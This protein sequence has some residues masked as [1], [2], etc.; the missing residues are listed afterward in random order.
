MSRRT[1]S[2]R[3]AVSVGL[4]FGHVH[5]RGR[6]SGLELD[7]ETGLRVYVRGG[8]VV[9]AEGLLSR[10]RALQAAGLSE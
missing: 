2:S 6:E 9:N 7:S 3:V 5:A 1:T 4:A 10:S 8:K